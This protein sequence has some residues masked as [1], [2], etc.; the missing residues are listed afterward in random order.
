MSPKLRRLATSVVWILFVFGVLRLII[1]LAYSF[2]SG[3]AE[4][5][6]HAFYDF[7]IGVASIFLAVVAL[8]IKRSLE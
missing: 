1:G 2:G 4:P 3:R 7:G 6:T 8:K 5:P